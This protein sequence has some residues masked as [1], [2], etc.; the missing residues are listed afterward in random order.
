MD[1]RDNES[2]ATS[3]DRFSRQDNVRYSGLSSAVVIAVT[4][5]I[6]AIVLGYWA[7]IAIPLGSVGNALARGSAPW[8]DVRRSRRMERH[9]AKESGPALG[10]TS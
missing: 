9:R 6:V 10:A 8:P 2:R 5:V 7:M 3:E 1:N 4:V